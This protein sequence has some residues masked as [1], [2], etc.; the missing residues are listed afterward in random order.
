MVLAEAAA[1]AVAIL[2]NDG[3]VLWI[4][5]CVR[6]VVGCVFIRYAASTVV[7]LAGYKHEMHDMLR[8][9]PGL[10]SRFQ[11]YVHF[12]DWDPDACVRLVERLMAEQSPRPFQWEAAEAQA[13]CKRLQSAF[14]DLSQRDV[15]QDNGELLVRAM[16]E[17]AAAA[18]SR[19]EL[20]RPGW[21][22]ARDA[23]GMFNLV[24]K[25]RD[26][27]MS[28]L[29]DA[30]LRGAG[31]ALVIRESDVQAATSEF[32]AARP[33]R[34]VLRE[35]SPPGSPHTLPPV[36]AA[37]Q[38]QSEPLHAHGRANRHGRR[39]ALSRAEHDHSDGSDGGGGSGGEN[40]DAS[41]ADEDQP[42]AKTA[43]GV[44]LVSLLLQQGVDEARNF[45]SLHSGEGLDDAYQQGL[46]SDLRRRERE[47]AEALERE[48]EAARLREEVR[49]REEALQRARDEEEA[50]RLAEELEAARKRAEELERQQRLLRERAERAAKIRRA[51]A[52]VGRCCQG[53]AWRRE[54][55]GFRCAG[56]SHTASFEQIAS[57]SGLSVSDVRGSFMS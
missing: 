6:A 35:P 22:N 45:L 12:E 36:R 40:S 11:E 53:Y 8:R 16:A 30:E 17:D 24:C 13:C 26:L 14:A 27:R 32:L 1:L 49:A 15:R 2:R 31:D 37:F 44:A 23:H 39:A 21:A 43:G 33:K 5:A 18:A 10:K 55:S 56:G 42:S 9:N 25:H 50:R 7:I 47:L 19:G 28:E 20:V 52:E 4:R 51:L 34:R 3:C 46:Q 57:Q 29:P 41:C 54:G 38:G 48:A